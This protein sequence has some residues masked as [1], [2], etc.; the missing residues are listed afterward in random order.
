MKNLIFYLKNLIYKIYFTHISVAEASGEHRREREE[1]ERD[2][3]GE[4]NSDDEGGKVN[5]EW[6]GRRRS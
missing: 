1:D 6:R 3:G 5:S 4:V 2:G